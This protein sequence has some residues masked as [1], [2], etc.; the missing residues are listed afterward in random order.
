VRDQKHEVDFC[1]IGGGMSGLCA[2]LAAARRG[3]RTALVQDRPVLG[4]NAS[5]EVRMWICGARGA[6]NRETGIVEE[7]E[8]EDLRR[9]PL[10][11]WSIWDSV[12][13]GAA[14]E[15]P[16]LEL[17]LNTV[18][19][20]LDMDGS[21]IRSV[22]C[23]GLT[24]ET[25]HT[26]SAPLFADCSGD[27]VLAPMGGARFRIGRE[28]RE[29]FGEELAPAEGDSKTMGM[30]CVMC[31]RETSRPR[32]FVPPAWSRVYR[33]D[34]D[35]PHRDHDVTRRHHCFWWIEL[36]GEDDSIHDSEKLRD[37][38][39]RVAFGVWDHVK[40]RGEHGAENWVLDWVGFLPGKRESRRYLGD[41]VLTAGEVRGGGRFA[42]LVAYGGWPMDDH[43]P[44]GVRGSGRPTVF[45]PAPSPYGIP[46]RSL[47]SRNVENL[48]CA[49]RNV[50]ATHLAMSSTRVMATCSLMGQAVG[51][52]AALGAAGRLSPRGVG[53]RALEELQAAL[54][55]D[56]CWLPGLRRE[57]PE[58]C[59]SARLSASEGDPAPLV[60]G[61]DRPLEGEGNA[62][63]ARPGAW[64]EY[65]FG[66]V[67]RLARM[68]AVFDSDLDRERPAMRVSYPLD[69]EEREP[70]A[71]LVKSFRVEVPDGSGGWRTVL[72]EEDNS[73]RL[74]R[75]E[76]DV[77][78]AAVRLVPESTRGAE[79]A[80]VFAFEVL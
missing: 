25:R 15:Q 63:E 28:G 42:D 65:D 74:V 71:A 19:L 56:D 30:S 47:Y 66:A 37:E 55:D 59:R 16:G 4:G 34:D 3:A 40:N 35:L 1:V 60:S 50:S 18:C 51:T 46:Y 10:A 14:L 29:E 12:L 5:S 79:R 7:L 26:I 52:A 54:M 24:D 64:V 53:Q 78:A 67:R 39:V 58:P 23:R 61:V 22:Q 69:Q 36:G 21:R 77:E 70:P 2:A 13:F 8:L 41:H 11:N 72:R 45:H 76:L 49:G 27:A 38:L 6:G 9:N 48:F 33:S 75:R 44:A 32:R 80:R 68:R 17:L 43:D 20:S 57:I 31:V 62:W 73:Q